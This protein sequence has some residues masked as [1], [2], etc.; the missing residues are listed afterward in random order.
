MRSPLSVAREQEIVEMAEAVADFYCP[1]GVVCPLKILRD[2]EIDHA[3]GAYGEKTFDGMLEYKDGKFFVY[4]NRDR[5]SLPHLPRGRF[6][7]SH[8][9]GHYFIPEHKLALQQG[10]PKHQ[11]KCGLFDG[12]SVKEE[13]EADVFAAN[14]LMPPSRFRVEMEKRK[15]RAP[16]EAI[17]EL[18]E[19]FR[20]SI[21]STAIQFASNHPDVVAMIRWNPDSIGWKRVEDEYFLRLRYRQWKL[22]SLE[23]LPRESATR[24]ALA[25]VEGDRCVHESVLTANFC[26]QQV[27]CAG[28][29]D[30]VLREQAVRLGN[31]GALTI[32]SLHPQF[33]LTARPDP[34][35]R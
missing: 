15:G 33:K 35:R 2:E 34:T 11:S 1:A 9:L 6:T 14:L 7:L 31:H 18:K 12:Q 20:T 29:R 23:G 21:L 13:L 3:V 10:A 27:A 17:L 4:C 16:L 5:E 25:A 30:L 32:L 28:D 22:E 19:H 8:E 26:F 24:A